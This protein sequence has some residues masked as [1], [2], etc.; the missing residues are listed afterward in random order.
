MLGI[1]W[2]WAMNSQNDWF[3][4]CISLITINI[5]SMYT[6]TSFFDVNVISK[7]HGLTMTK[8][9]LVLSLNMKHEKKKH[10]VHKT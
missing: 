10:K 1:F 9:G 5:S 4:C 6:I 7:G 8:L 2:K 3:F